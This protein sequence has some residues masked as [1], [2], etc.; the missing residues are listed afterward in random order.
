[1]AG[2]LPVGRRFVAV[3]LDPSLNQAQLLAGQ[4]AGQDFAVADAN[5]G[6]EFAVAGV[7]ARQVVVTMIR[8]VHPDD[9]AVEHRDDR[10]VAA[11]DDRAGGQISRLTST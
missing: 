1:M 5:R 7:D 8:Q 2:Q 11:G 9:D 6:Y 4:P 10:L 3:Q